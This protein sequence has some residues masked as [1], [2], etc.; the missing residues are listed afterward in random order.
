MSKLYA[1]TDAYQALWSLVEDD[2][3]DLTIIEEALQSVEDAIEV[4]A[5][6]IALFIRDLDD[7]AKIIKAEEERLYGRR[8]AIENKRDGIKS[9]L[10]QAMDHMEMPKIKTKVYTISVQNNPATVAITDETLIPDRFLTLIPASYQ[11]RKKDVL[12]A[13]KNGEVIPG[14]QLT[15][16]RS[17][18]IR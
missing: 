18:R 3:T 6:N 2:E 17:L 7:E 8:K 13:W 4:K 14:S 5:Q 10:L 15:Q 1:L 11:V 9:F 12:V 16:G